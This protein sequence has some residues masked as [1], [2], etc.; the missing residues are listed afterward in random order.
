[1]DPLEFPSLLDRI[2]SPRSLARRT[3]E[4]RWHELRHLDESNVRRDIVMRG[5][6][7]ES[8]IADRIL[9]MEQQVIVLEGS[10]R[11]EH[12]EEEDV[13]IFLQAEALVETAVQASDIPTIVSIFS[14]SGAHSLCN[15]Y[16]RRLQ[17]LCL[18]SL[19][20]LCHKNSSNKSRFVNCGGI[21]AILTSTRIHATCLPILHKATALVISLAFFNDSSNAFVDRMGVAHPH[22][23][24]MSNLRLIKRWK[25]Q[26]D[27]LDAGIASLLITTTTSNNNDQDHHLLADGP[28]SNIFTLIADSVDLDLFHV[29]LNQPG[30][31]N[32][33]YERVL[34]FTQ[35][36]IVCR[37]LAQLVNDPHCLRRRLLFLRSCLASYLSDTSVTT[38]T[39]GAIIL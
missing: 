33:N 16:N 38:D 8:V 20:A 24:L 34:A 7:G 26:D 14:G 39:L 21:H 31:E 4:I 5:T 23:E 6:A 15:L 11:Q 27:T 37:H 17:I 10:S 18:D 3:L 28:A 32:G 22:K 12:E 13:R 1:M 36:P 19:Q 30:D 35:I 2:F 9:E 29:R 25:T